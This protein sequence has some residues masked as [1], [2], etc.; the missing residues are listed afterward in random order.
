MVQWLENHQGLHFRT[1][2]RGPKNSLCHHFPYP[3]AIASPLRRWEPEFSKHPPNDHLD[4]K[5]GGSKWKTNMGPQMWMSSYSS[6]VLTIQLLGYL[7]LTH[8]QMMMDSEI[9]ESIVFLFRVYESKDV[10]KANFR[11]IQTLTVAHANATPGCSIGHV[12]SSLAIWC[13]KFGMDQN[14]LYHIWGRW[15]SIC[16]PAIVRFM[17]VLTHTVCVWII[18]L[19]G[20][21]KPEEA[22]KICCSGDD[23]SS[24][25]EGAGC[26]VSTCAVRDSSEAPRQSQLHSQLTQNT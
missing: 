11:L 13:S 1:P 2:P 25:N 19:M 17:S 16:T 12:A 20:G 7:I 6:L 4:I 18:Q 21:L 24:V 8:T 9:C 26:F 3:I 14:L 23:S 22:L 15:T 10:T 5:N